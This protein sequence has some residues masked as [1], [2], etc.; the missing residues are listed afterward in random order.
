MKNRIITFG[1]IAFSLLSCKKEQVAPLPPTPPTPVPTSPYTEIGSAVTSSNLTVTLYADD[2]LSVGY[3]R[4]YAEVKDQTGTIVDNAT[5]EYAPLM[6]MGMMQ[7]AC[8]VE[9][10]GFNNNSNFYEGAMVFTMSSATGTWYLEVLVNGSPATFTLN[11]ADAPLGIKEVGTYSGTDGINYIIS[12]KR[13]V[14]WSVGSND[15]V[16]LLHKRQD[17]MHFP[18]VDSMELVFT[19]EMVSMG[20]GST[21]NV[22]PVSIGSGYYQGIAS[23]SMSGDW[24]FHFELKKNGVTI[25]PD[26]YLDILF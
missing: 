24:R 9:Q 10:P 16:V 2:D 19:P 12:L 15:L 25:H 4:L 17:M 26:A 6:D 13:P 22:D 23:L 21:G 7:H 11:V 20:H 14:A 8:P 18:V 3:S 1:L 5:V